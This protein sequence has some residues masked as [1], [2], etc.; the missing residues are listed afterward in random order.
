MWNRQAS[1]SESLT[2]QARTWTSLS[3]SSFSVEKSIS[4]SLPLLEPVARDVPAVG[5]PVLPVP[6]GVGGLD[7]AEHP[8]IQVLPLLL[9]DLVVLQH[10]PLPSPFLLVDL[11]R[12]FDRPGLPLLVP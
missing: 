8:A 1:M 9:R 3:P 12:L 6:E 2:F 4:F 10:P 5:V 11:V 7:G